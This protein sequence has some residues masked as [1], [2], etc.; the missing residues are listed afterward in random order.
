MIAFPCSG[1][2]KTLS[3]EEKWAGQQVR[4]SQCG[5]MVLVPD[6][7]LPDPLSVGTQSEDATLLPRGRENLP[8]MPP[9]DL[10]DF[11][12]P[13]EAVDELGRL[14]PYR[15]QKI[16]GYGG[17]GV[18]FEA[19][20]PQLQRQ[21]ALKA[22]LPTL[23]VS[24]TSRQRFLREARAAAAVTHD[25]IV[26]IYQVGEDRGVPYLAMPLLEGESLYQRFL[27]EGR[28]PLAEVVRIGREV[29]EGLGAAH[30]RGLVH[31][32]IKPANIWLE[33]SRGRVKILDFGLARP[34]GDNVQLTQQ[35]ALVGTPAYMSPEQVA[36]QAIDHRSDLFSL[37]VVLYLLATGEFPFKGND[38]VATLVEIATVQPR[39]PRERNP[40]VPKALSDLVMQ[41]L[42][43][44]PAGRPPSAEAVIAALE[45]CKVASAERPSPH[46]K[47]SPR[48]RWLMAGAACLLAALLVGGFVFFRTEPPPRN[49][50]PDSHGGQ[51]D[52]APAPLALP[53]G[54]GPLRRFEGHSKQVNRVASTRDN[55]FAVTGSIDGTVRVWDMA[56]GKELRRCEG[57]TEPVWALAISPDDR[58]I[59]AGGGRATPNGQGTAG[60]DFTL[61]LWDRATGQLVRRFA[62]HTGRIDSV[63][64]CADG[65]RALSGSVDGTQR[66]WDVQTGD[67]LARL[68]GHRG[69]VESVAVS[70][71]GKQAVSAGTDRTLRLWDLASG[72]VIR[73]F[74]GPGH[75]SFIPSVAFSPDGRFVL[76][77][78]M[79]RTMRMWDVAT[80]NEVRRFPEHP[81]GINSVAFSPDG[82]LLLSASG[83][84]PRTNGQGYGPCG[85]DCTL[86]LWD[87][88]TG[89]EVHRFEAQGWT[90]TSAT[91]TTDGRHAL[92]ASADGSVCLWGL[93]EKAR[94]EP[95]EPASGY[96]A[97]FGLD[98]EG[99]R[100]WLE[101]MRR[102]RLRP[103]F[104]G[105]HD[106]GDK[107]LFA[108]IALREKNA[109]PWEARLD[110]DFNADAQS[111]ET[112]KAKG[113]RLV[114]HWGYRDGAQPRFAS[115]WAQKE[116]HKDWYSWTNLDAAGFQAKFEAMKET[117]FRPFQVQGYP[118]GKSARF[119]A[120]FEPESGPYLVR[121]NLTAQEL[122]T[123]LRTRGVDGYRP[124]S[125]SGYPN[126]DRT[127]FSLVLLKDKP[128]LQW[129]LRRDLTP[130]QL[131]QAHDHW[132]SRGFRPQVLSG[133]LQ[134]KATRYLGIWVRDEFADLP[135]PR[136]GPV[137]PALKEFDQ[138]MISFMRERGI[139]AGSLAVHKDGRLVLTRGYGYAD[140]G[141]KLPVAS[142]TPFRLA[143]LSKPITA[144]AIRKLI[145]D[146]KLKLDTKVFPLLAI[147]VPPGQKVDPRWQDITVQHLLEHQGGWDRAGPRDP[148]F[149]PGEIAAGLGKPDPPTATDFVR[150]MAGQPLDFAPGSKTV[151][152]NFGYCVLGRVIEK[153][154][155]QGY[156][157]YVQ[158]EIMAP[159]GIKS[160]EL[161]RSLPPERNPREPYYADPIRGRNVMQPGSGEPVFV[162]DGNFCVEAMDAHGG[163]I[164]SAVDLARFLEAYQP[165]GEPV[166]GPTGPYVHFGSMP[167]TFTMALRT[168]D[169]TLMVALFN[170]RKDSSGLA[171]ESIREKLEQI[172]ARV[173][174]WP[175]EELRFAAPMALQPVR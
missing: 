155:G 125:A 43:K 63:V 19:N 111:F 126:G 1:C 136:S 88:E 78:S 37:G 135:L 130:A 165:N 41:L 113:Y 68:T 4:C 121:S 23:A 72:K 40:A 89:R 70:P 16:L 148:M 30:A 151:Y 138:A 67:T 147:P 140:R 48:S 85:F 162:P 5:R 133:Y 105:A 168:R 173:P 91:F 114:S 92:S 86:R 38:P 101:R 152:S 50:E 127:S 132:T 159:P 157:E 144:A 82:R 24:E 34:K 160:V 146:G 33:G 11:L 6:T 64:F 2:G 115:L 107:P 116:S 123:V 47:R 141:E 99:C 96:R 81:S 100:S 171:Y 153:V 106:A 108:G 93:P 3:V 170:Q 29:A 7:P 98:A 26:G 57:L 15:V 20:D 166:A 56:S 163:L 9:R 164:A 18:V 17:M 55:R 119:A 83:S 76:S 110:L 103:V 49:V 87:A 21:V 90:L 128:S 134:E 58:W 79:D 65:Q 39:P 60:N 109:L 137:V 175:A 44:D 54:V 46:G 8:D 150:Y 120:L 97:V 77:G 10:Y 112:F 161:A 117:G 69:A 94:G 35:G 174:R 27:R 62:G 169:G 59:L 156:V 95:V 42:A 74:G 36:G 154:T 52:A 51:A 84:L 75:T 28:L 122:D 71:D 131:V 80:G 12:A 25:H 143:S 22:M 149:R 118:E 61:R 158:K 31:R 73:L 124:L 14:G 53:D 13:P 102:E 104:L 45:Q 172:A 129:V 139:R 145:R 66:L 167:G 32:D 142:D